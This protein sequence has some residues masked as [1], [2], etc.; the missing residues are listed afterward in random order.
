MFVSNFFIKSQIE[1]QKFFRKWDTMFLLIWISI[2]QGEIQYFLWDWEKLEQL[3]GLFLKLK[4]ARWF[5]L[6]FLNLKY[7]IVPVN[8]NLQFIY[9]IYSTNLHFKYRYLKTYIF[10]LNLHHQT[11]HYFLR[12]NNHPKLLPLKFLH[13]FSIFNN[14]FHSYHGINIH[15][16]CFY[17]LFLSICILAV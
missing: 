3:K 1:I 6:T 10:N 12:F 5:F 2:L 13:Y 14:I 16:S 17:L 9:F 8:V 11:D 4:E 7:L 15:K